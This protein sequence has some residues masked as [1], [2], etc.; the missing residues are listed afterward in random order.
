[1]ELLIYYDLFFILSHNT[2][3]IIVK[4]DSRLRERERERQREKAGKRESGKEKERERD[5]ERMSYYH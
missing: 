3:K 1:M 4:R 5:R 2:C